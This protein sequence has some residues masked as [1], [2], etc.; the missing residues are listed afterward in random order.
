MMRDQPAGG[1]IFN[2]DGA[3]GWDG[4][5]VFVGGWMGGMCVHGWGAWVGGGGLWGEHSLLLLG[6][7]VQQE[8]RWRAWRGTRKRAWRDGQGPGPGLGF[9]PACP[10]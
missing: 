9:T 8:R 2:M 10:A 4:V 5:C 7:R 1:H 3:G 6:V